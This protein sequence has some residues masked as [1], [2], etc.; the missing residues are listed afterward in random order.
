MLGALHTTH[1]IGVDSVFPHCD[2]SLCMYS[3][4]LHLSKL[5]MANTD[6]KILIF[7]ILASLL[8]GIDT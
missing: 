6:A 7:P 3:L 4:N 8:S 1:V 2:A 5:V